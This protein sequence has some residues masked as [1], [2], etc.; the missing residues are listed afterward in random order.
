MVKERRNWKTN[1]RE[2]GEEEDVRALLG[3]LN[4]RDLFWLSSFSIAASEYKYIIFN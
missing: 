2:I 4:G 3:K 1:G